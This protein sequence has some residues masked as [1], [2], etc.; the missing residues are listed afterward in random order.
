PLYEANDIIRNCNSTLDKVTS[1]AYQLIDQRE[2]ES[3]VY[4]VKIGLNR[5]R[6]IMTSLT[7]AVDCRQMHTHYQDGIEGACHVALPG[8]CFLLLSAAVSGLLFTLLVV[9]ASRAWRHFGSS[10]LFEISRLAD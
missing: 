8:Y 9:L 7:A 3:H 6:D 10:C 1:I 5:S 2:L 4:G